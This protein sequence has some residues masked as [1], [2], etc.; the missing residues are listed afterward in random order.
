MEP[1]KTLSKASK[2]QGLVLSDDE[3]AIVKGNV[4]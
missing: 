1:T 2:F 4:T 3:E